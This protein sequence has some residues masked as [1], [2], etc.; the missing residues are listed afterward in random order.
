MLFW[1]LRRR[2]Q[3]R[4]DYYERRRLQVLRFMSDAS[5]APVHLF[6]DGLRCLVSERNT[7]QTNVPW[8]SSRI[9]REACRAPGILGLCCAE[10]RQKL[11]TLFVDIALF[12]LLFASRLGHVFWFWFRLGGTF[13]SA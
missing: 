13:A 12:Y 1:F 2:L 6:G 10:Q 8:S 5:I 3:I 4:D 7:W 9:A 11:E